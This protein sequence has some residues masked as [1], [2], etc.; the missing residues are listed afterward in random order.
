MLN[1]F[2]FL[3]QDTFFFAWTRQEIDRKV[4]TSMRIWSPQIAELL[5]V[6]YHHGHRRR[7]L[8]Q[9]LFPI[10]C[11][12]IRTTVLTPR[13]PPLA[14]L[15]GQTCKICDACPQWSPFSPS[16][17]QTRSATIT[18]IRSRDTD[19]E[20]GNTPLPPLHYSAHRHEQRKGGTRARSSFVLSLAKNRGGEGRRRFGF[21][22][23]WVSKKLRFLVLS[24]REC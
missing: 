21:G 16:R 2:F 12:P 14:G 20:I 23:G 22:R 19:R 17:S 5:V 7:F 9:F 11:E 4:R 13:T 8:L 15:V 18:T 6:Y 10:V 1:C 24:L 3:A